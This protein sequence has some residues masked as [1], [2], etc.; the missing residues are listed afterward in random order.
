MKRS[1]LCLRECPLHHTVLSIRHR[2]RRA[3]I[4]RCPVCIHVART[5]WRIATEQFQLAYARHRAREKGGRFAKALAMVA[6]LLFSR[7]IQAAETLQGMPLRYLIGKDGND[8]GKDGAITEPGYDAT[9]VPAHGIGVRYANLFCEK[10][11]TCPGP[12]LKSTGTAAQYHEGKLDPRGAGWAKNLNAQFERARKQGFGFIEL[13]NS[14]SYGQQAVMGAIELA[15]AFGLAVLAKNPLLSPRW[16]DIYV[17][18]PNIAGVIVERGA[19]SPKAMDLLRRKV[20][21]PALAV[22]FVAFGDG[23][24]W[25]DSIAKD[26]RGVGMG[27][28]YSPKGEYGAVTDIMKPSNR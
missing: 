16:A 25:A 5:K 15:K 27:V 28:S 13:D 7:P 1:A 10:G 4:F 24:A 11:H 17:A 19:G 26:A 22:Y 20:G 18:N 6:L 9:K 23:R 2:A 3:E 8:P 12:Y 14:D 21:R